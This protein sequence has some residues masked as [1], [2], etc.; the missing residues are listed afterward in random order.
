MRLRLGLQ[1][2]LL[3]A[4]P[5]AA[6]VTTVAP[7]DVPAAVIAAIHQV[8]PGL[9][10]TEAE[11]KVRDGRTY[12]DVGGEAKG[13]EIEFDVLQTP[14]G[15]S[16]VEIERDIDWAQAPANVRAAAGSVS[17]VRVIES[18]QM[19]GVVIY[20]LFAEGKPQTPSMEV[21]LQD[22][23]ASVLTEVWPH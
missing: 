7:S 16:V 5:A 12:F 20:E 22:G 4:L 17:P 2:A 21:K 19:D 1:I 9:K 15:W 8:E 10:V 18:R 11:K 6:Q 14:E 3:A 13:E 23:A